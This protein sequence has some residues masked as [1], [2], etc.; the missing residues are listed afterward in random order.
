M[1]ALVFSLLVLSSTSSLADIPYY[2]CFKEA[3]ERQNLPK[4]AIMAI[5][6]TESSF[7]PKALNTS[8][9]NGSIDYGI[10]QINS[11]WLPFLR[12]S[13]ITKEHL[14]D[15][16]ININVG[17]YIFATNI[18][19]HGWNWKGIGAYNAKTDYKR[20]AYA[21]KVLK[22]WREVSQIL[23]NQQVQ[24]ETNKGTKNDV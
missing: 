3:A 5:A 8:N 15:P 19:D 22:N 17:A 21:Q 18:K 2:S 6:K 24:N 9:A 1:K 13:G 4:E 20:Y 11:S 7:N 14:M 16:C 23:Y 10:M 12:K